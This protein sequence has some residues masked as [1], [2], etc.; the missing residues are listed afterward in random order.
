MSMGQYD[1]IGDEIAVTLPFNSTYYR[2]LL[3][4]R[5]CMNRYVLQYIDSTRNIDWTRYDN[6]SYDNGWL[7]EP[8]GTA[9]MIIMNYRR[10]PNN[11]N[12]WFW[13]SNYGGEA[14]LAISSITFDGVTIG[15]HNG[16]TALNLL[17]ATGRSEI[18]LEHEFSHKLFGLYGIPLS[19]DGYHINM[20]FM[21][22]GHNET[23][24]LY[25]PMERSAPIVDYV[26]I[27]FINTTGIYN[28][29][30]PDFVESGISFKIKIPGTSDD[31]IWIA[32]HQKK[33]LYDG[34]ARG[35]SNC[36]TTNFAEIDPYCSD[37]K[38]LFIYRQGTGCSNTNQ[39]YDITS[40][41][42]KFTWDTN[43]TVSVPPQNYHHALGFS[44]PILKTLVGK[45]YAG[46]DKYNKHHAYP[47][48]N[49]GTWI[50][51]NECSDL[52]NDF[53]ISLSYRGDS[54]DPFNIGYD[55][56][57]SPYSNPSS[58]FC[59]STLTG[60][61]IALMEQNSTTGAIIVK[62]YYNNDTQALI[63][64]PPSKPKNLRVVKDFFGA[65]TGV[66]GGGDPGT[67]HPKITWDKNI[68]PDFNTTSYLSNPEEVEP[69][70]HLY[71]GYNTDCESEPTYSFL[72]AVNHNDSIY[73]DNSLT[74][75][76][77]EH[78]TIQYCTGDLL[79]YSYKILAKD[80]HGSESVKSERGMVSGYSTE[81]GG[82]DEDNR[83]VSNNENQSDIPVVF[84]L[85]QN[86]PNPFNPTTNIQYDL[87]SDNFVSIKI[88]DITGREITTLVNEFKTAGRYSVGFNGAN[89]SS[90]IYYYKIEAGNFTQVRKMILL[91]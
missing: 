75:Y 44:M 6:W 20:G 45:R 83:Q 89:I 61:T 18:I 37:G 43:R 56:V 11:S 47:I 23:S 38:G 76:D 32:N 30:L 46:K 55:E 33:S 34:I 42:G 31:H 58:S 17:H 51:D 24:Y 10:I 70:Y 64:L 40:A 4:N 5:S 3:C 41:E 25:T 8:D 60:L 26:P 63:D 77:P 39:P 36:Y 68:E 16:V 59:D 21:T 87:P 90:G 19:F 69:K 29:T 65:D 86:Y 88:F 66:F 80:K 13:S 49:Y 22:P 54:F 27:N 1:V 82:G 79:T 91:K 67:F 9:E 15:F 72:A 52:Y 62:I 85:K 73:I 28:D 14:S 71:R 35:G 48:T 84:S 7:F 12:S 57:F 74:L 2:D 50:T 78:A 53:N 81:C